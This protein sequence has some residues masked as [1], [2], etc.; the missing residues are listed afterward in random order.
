MNNY[1]VWWD[2]TITIYNKYIDPQTQLAMWFRHTIGNCFWQRIRDKVK[3]GDTVL[4]SNRT[5]CRIPENVSFMEKHLWAAL[6]V[7]AK[8]GYFTLGQG[9][10][11]V[12]G[13]V[14]DAI[15]EYTAGHRSSDLI[16]KYQDLQGCMEIEMAA[17]NVGPGRGLPHY[18]AQGV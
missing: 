6:P 18:R 17:I 12:N 14:D 13:A 5:V 4:E 16:S 7:D 10:I 3:L 8:E 1:P 9:D 11:I 15:D 2:A